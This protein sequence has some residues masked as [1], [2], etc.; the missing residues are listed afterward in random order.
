MHTTWCDIQARQIRDAPYLRMISGSNFV[1]LNRDSPTRQPGNGNPYSQDVSLASAS[2]ITSTNWQT[3][4]NLGSDHLPILIS[5][6]MDFT[7]NPIP[8]RTSFNLKKVNWDRY[9]KE[10]GQSEQKTA[11]NKLPKRRKDLA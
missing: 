8:H 2:L 7:I 3:N 1:I 4:T 5:L 10:V 6:Q 11:S 9:H